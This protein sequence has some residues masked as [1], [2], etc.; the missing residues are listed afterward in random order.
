MQVC[1][2]YRVS[3]SIRSSP[4][5]GILRSNYYYYYYYVDAEDGDDADIAFQG[6]G[7]ILTPSRVNGYLIQGYLTIVP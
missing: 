4:K 7:V 5:W 1:A 3:L 2:D 6:C